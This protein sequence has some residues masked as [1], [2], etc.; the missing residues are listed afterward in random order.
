MKH[1][2][3][4][5]LPI[6]LLIT[7]CL[8]LTG[9]FLFLL[10]KVN[11]LPSRYFMAACLGMIV[12]VLVL[13]L[14]LRRFRNCFRCILGLILS[15]VYCGAL[16]AGGFY[17]QRTV[18]TVESITAVPTIHVSSMNIFVRTDDPAQSLKDAEN[19]TFGILLIQDRDVTDKALDQL[20]SDLGHGV[21]VM[22]YESPVALV[23]ALLN[24]NVDAILFN[25]LFFKLVETN[26][27]I[28]D[29]SSSL[30]ALT[31]LEVKTEVP[32]DVT[33][34]PT[35]EVIEPETEDRILTVYISGVDAVGGS[36]MVGGG[37][38]N[39]IAVVNVDTRQVLLVTTPRD[40]Y[41]PF[42]SYGM[43]DKLTHAGYYGIEESMATLGNL[44]G[45]N[46]DTYF[47]V[48]FGGFEDIVDAV[49]GVDVDCE[50]YFTSMNDQGEVFEYEKGRI[51]LAGPAALMYVRERSAFSD[52]D[53]ARGRHQMQVIKAI[54]DKAMST[55]LLTHFSDLM[56]SIEGNFVTN[57]PYEIMTSVVQDQLDNG[58]SWNIVQYSVTG[59][60][61]WKYSFSYGDDLS[62]VTPDYASVDVAIDLIRQVFEGEVV[63]LP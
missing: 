36:I 41:V 52:G 32:V 56:A 59:Y 13:F 60:V 23:N 1:T 6:V 3:R 7:S 57:M 53:F 47:R 2:K 55:E 40:Y 63:R 45:I 61:D 20:E 8:V 15:V 22:G 9:L 34:A 33:P 14:L 44:Y 43:P 51:H 19:Y 49:G 16:V 31:V 27:S 25:T 17:L 46:L 10:K 58:G 42:A 11:V 12:F 5:V 29:M 18:K 38:V 4:P 26:A 30:R 24:E 28:P 50:Q 21:S 54:L 48:D 62:V 35:V 37:D 39:I